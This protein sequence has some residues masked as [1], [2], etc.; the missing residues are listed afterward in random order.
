MESY[1]YVLFYIYT[2]DFYVF[3]YLETYQYYF[4]NNV[5]CS[6]NNRYS[7]TAVVER[8]RRTIIVMKTFGK[9]STGDSSLGPRGQNWAMYPSLNE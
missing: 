5:A 8:M 3:M 2:I 4:H 6:R 9:G 1:C 7:N